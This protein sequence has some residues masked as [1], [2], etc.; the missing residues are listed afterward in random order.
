MVREFW[1]PANG[2]GLLRLFDA[3]PFLLYLLNVFWS[4]LSFLLNVSGIGHFATGSLPGESDINQE[5][6]SQ[7]HSKVEV[8]QSFR[9]IPT[10]LS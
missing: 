10:Q 4:W 9:N 6:H 1:Q 3:I 5:A 2:S 8:S 7:W